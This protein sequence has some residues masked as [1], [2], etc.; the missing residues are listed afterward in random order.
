M[1]HGFFVGV[2]EPYSKSQ[3]DPGN[4]FGIRFVAAPFRHQVYILYACTVSNMKRPAATT[5]SQYADSSASEE[6]EL[7]RV[8]VLVLDD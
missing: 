7:A 8:D 3:P 5:V 4:G 1:V 6:I 2:Y